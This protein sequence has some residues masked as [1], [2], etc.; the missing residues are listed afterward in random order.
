M[1][2]F[3]CGILALLALAS[4]VPAQ[5]TLP[6]NTVVGR[7]G[8]GPGPS[9]AIPF[10]T[11]SGVLFGSGSGVF[12][13]TLSGD[14]NYGMVG[15]DRTVLIN[16][17]L[18]A[19]RTVTLFAAATLATGQQICIEDAFGGVTATN[20][21]TIARGGTDTINGA[22]SYV[23]TSAFGGACLISDGSSK[24][25]VG[26]IQNG[27]LANMPA[28]TI[29]CN[30]TGAVAAV[31]DCTG[32]QAE[33]ILQF[34]Q[35]GTGA[36]ANRSLDT[37]LKDWVSALD[38]AVGNCST[39]DST[40]IQNAINSLTNGGTLYFPPAPGGCYAIGSATA[41]TMPTT[42]A[43]TL[44]GSGFGESGANIGTATGGTVLKATASITSMITTGT[45]FQRGSRISSMTFDGDALAQYN[46]KIDQLDAATF[47]NLTLYNATLI[48]FRLGSGATNTQENRVMNIRIDNP[49]TT[50]LANLPTYN[51]ENNGI[52]NDIVNLKAV[53]AKTANIH[54]A[55]TAA[56]NKYVNIHGYDFFSGATQP[57]TNNL[58]VDGS[59]EQITTCEMDGSGTADIQVNGFGNII[60]GCMIQ[61]QG[62]TAQIGVN[63]ATGTSGNIVSSSIFANSTTANSIVQA[64]TAGGPGNFFYGNYNSTQG[65]VIGSRFTSTA[66]STLTGGCNGAGSSI[67][68]G[69]NKFYGRVTGANTGTP[70]SCVVT[71]GGGGFAAI[72]RCVASGQVAALTTVVPTTTTLTVNF[73]ATNSQIFSYYCEGQ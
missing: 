50:V 58:L 49:K 53:N 52:N 55:A 43:V 61:F 54:I 5:Q 35:S 68:A 14:T 12:G 41:I 32:A 7:L 66:L 37:R 44:M 33:S 10:T 34:T 57:V 30:S 47:D 36:V 64:G 28:T 67:D 20:T 9:Q 73:G 13:L 19:P 51:F 31:V 40:N 56:G 18:T 71:F 22:T 11:L 27:N 6:P 2:K 39:D 15:T 24:W 62:I 1:K 60:S 72:P 29:K 69:S 48:N 4:P 42:K 59:F 25:T 16:A 38:F 46:L 26:K 70:T 17:A 63:F 8:I 21:L 45:S 3:I 65:T 23:L